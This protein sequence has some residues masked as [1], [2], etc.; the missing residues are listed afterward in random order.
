MSDFPASATHNAN[1][2][3][4]RQTILSGDPFAVLD[5]LDAATRQAI[6][7]G[8]DA[9]CA[10]LSATA[11]AFMLVD[12][13]RFTGWRQWI[14]RF[15]DSDARMGSDQPPDLELARANGALISGLLRGDAIETLTPLALRLE[16]LLD[17][18]DDSIRLTL[19]A[20]A[21]LPWMQMSKN[22]AAAQA[23]HARIEAAARAQP[24]PAPGD[25]YMR[26]SWLCSWAQHLHFSGER[27][28][29]PA[30]LQV[31]DD[32]LAQ[33][34][35]PH[36]K[37]RRMRLIAEQAM[38]NQDLPAAERAVRE[39]LDAMDARRP[40]ERVIYNTVAVALA[41][42]QNDP[43][44][45]LLL[46]THNL[47]D[48][49]AADCPPSIATVYRMVETRV[50][51]RRGDY[52]MAAAIFEQCVEHA[53]TAHAATYRGF[54]AL[55]RA[56][57]AHREDSSSREPMRE[58]LRS[59][60]TMARSISAI[61]FFFSTPVARAAVCAL[62]LREGIETEFIQASLKQAPVPPP[63]W[64]DEHW[65]WALSLRCFGGFRSEG[66][67][68]EGRGGGKASNK[69]MSL[70]ML[71]AIHGAQGLPVA[72]AA[73]ALWPGQDGDQAENSLSVT[74]LRLRRM[75]AEADL[76]E[77]RGGWLHLNAQRVWTD[78][79]ALEAQLDALPDEA[80]LTEAARKA[81]VARIF[82]LYRGECLF[83]IDDE[84]A[85]SRAVHYRG[86]VT[87]ATKALL[88]G[89]LQA[90]HFAAAELL[91]TLAHE[92]GIGASRLLNAALPLQSSAPGASPAWVLL[93]R[94]VEM[95]ESN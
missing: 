58:L 82:D 31:L 41:T 53:H 95:L 49:E 83:G 71:I 74:L 29:L 33:T 13:A 78:V 61:N 11:L 87:T 10:A 14:Q 70:L 75:H 7:A 63:P 40:L 57:L 46:A 85:R 15:A 27:E 67:A 72:L 22:P 34:G 66:L 50:Y 81:L 55:A 86:R 6:A 42:T 28:R 73:D 59:G 76:V 44:R 65:P 47:R 21:L 39:L 20:S 32:Y 1:W 9:A 56:L 16:S 84:W 24:A 17:V 2:P 8:D 79:M 68:A 30:A 94:H 62:A 77:R 23:L 60:L 25:P 54:A 89:A 18:A 92:R 43:E 91:L 69:P 93:Q 38:F 51:L 3:Q 36:F 45:A 35:S 4:T 5:K 12:W 37:F 19:A 64:A 48:L 80:T 90:G 26:A 88:L 52:A